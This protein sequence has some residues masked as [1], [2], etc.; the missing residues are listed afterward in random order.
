MCCVLD[1]FVRGT[2]P[3]IIRIPAVLIIN[4][5]HVLGQIKDQ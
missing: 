5:S 3:M 2:L 1:T 4:I